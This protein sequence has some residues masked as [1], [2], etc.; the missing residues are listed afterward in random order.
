MAAQGDKLP[1]LVSAGK[2]PTM[3][4]MAETQTSGPSVASAGEALQFAIEAA[5][6][7]ADNRIEEIAVLDLRELSNIADFF[8]IGTGTSDRQM[9]AALDHIAVRARSA[10][11]RPLGVSDSARGAWLLADYVDVVI[12][13]F[14]AEHREYYDLDGLWG[15]APRV[16]WEPEALVKQAESA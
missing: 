7:A 12:H 8:V 2:R 13:L 15:A 16:T 3:N 14:D 6:V 10:G 11:R 4:G 1:E 9:H 5:H